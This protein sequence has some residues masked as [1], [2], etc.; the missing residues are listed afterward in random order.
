MSVLPLYWAV[1]YKVNENLAAL[2]VAVVSFDGQSPPYTTTEPL[3]GR[4][5]EQVA[6]QQ[7]QTPKGVLG[8]HVKIASEYNNDSIAVRQAVYN[9]HVRQQSS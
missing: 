6:R 9:E 7:A 5:V 4:T 3:I 1:L 8:F 2:T